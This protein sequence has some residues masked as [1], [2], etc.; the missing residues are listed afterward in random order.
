MFFIINISVLSSY[1][2][3][4]TLEI[5]LKEYSNTVLGAVSSVGRALP[6]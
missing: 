4:Y 2:Q 5:N 3:A 6:F 1:M